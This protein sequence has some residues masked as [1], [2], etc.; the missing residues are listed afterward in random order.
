[1][2]LGSMVYEFAGILG[3]YVAPSLDK[4]RWLLSDAAKVLP[5]VLKKL[6]ER[7]EDFVYLL[8]LSVKDLEFSM[9]LRLVPVQVLAGLTDFPMAE[10]LARMTTH[11]GWG[12]LAIYHELGVWHSEVMEIETVKPN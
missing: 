3:A 11:R 1:M 10:L 2:N 5:T 7:P 6:P 12:F 4:A 8:V 9:A